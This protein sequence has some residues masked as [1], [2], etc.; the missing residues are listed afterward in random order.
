MLV[1]QLARTNYEFVSG[2]RNCLVSLVLSSTCLAVLSS[3]VQAS[4]VQSSLIW[5]SRSVALPLVSVFVCSLCRDKF[6][7][8]R[9]CCSLGGDPAMASAHKKAANTHKETLVAFT[10]TNAGPRSF[11]TGDEGP[12]D[13][14]LAYSARP[15]LHWSR[16]HDTSCQRGEEQPPASVQFW[17][18]IVGQASDLARRSSTSSGQSARRPRSQMLIE[19]AS[20]LDG[21]ARTTGR[22]N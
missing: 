3:P 1:A 10:C 8:G 21:G 22:A 12:T 4:A 20:Q 13:C 18:A 17:L 19:F 15:A 2:H 7:L 9:P 11:R 16:V 14:P 6:S 5:S